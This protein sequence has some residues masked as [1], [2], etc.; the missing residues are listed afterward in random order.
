MRFIDDVLCLQPSQGAKSRVVPFKATRVDFDIGFERDVGQDAPGRRR[1]RDDEFAGTERIAGFRLELK[2][3]PLGAELPVDQRVSG[4]T[5]IR[6]PRQNI[7][8]SGRSLW[9]SAG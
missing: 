9:G 7:V 5:T 4:L 8:R 6:Q 1:T 3:H 2:G